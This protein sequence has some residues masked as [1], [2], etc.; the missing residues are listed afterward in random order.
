MIIFLFITNI[1]TFATTIIFIVQNK[2]NKKNLLEK[3]KLVKSLNENLEKLQNEKDILADYKGRF[4]Q[5]TKDSKKIYEENKS[6]KEENIILLNE[7]NELEKKQAILKQKK[8]D[9]LKQKESLEKDKENFLK[10]LSLDLIQQSSEINEKNLKQNQEKIKNITEELLKN[11]ENV[12]NKVFSLDDDNKRREKALDIMRRALL[13]PGG[14]GNS[15]E[16]TLGNILKASGLK[17][18]KNKED[19]GDYILQTSFNTQSS[20][21]IKRPDAIIYLPNNNYIV[22]DSKSSSH[23]INLQEAIDNK[24]K[25][26]EKE[27]LKKIKDRMRK[28]LEDLKS[29]DYEKEYEKYLIKKENDVPPTITMIMFLQTEK[30]LEIIRKA[31][32]NFELMCYKDNIPLATPLGLINLLNLSKYSINKEKQDKNIVKLKW[33]IEKLLNNIITLFSGAKD[34]GKGLKKA[35]NNYDKFAKVFNKN[36]LKRVREI[37]KLGIKSKEKNIP[38]L[39]QYELATTTIE[40]EIEEAKTKED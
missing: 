26:K 32:K 31:D 34:L 39:E 27:I 11:F 33:E 35:L 5:L 40:G 23:F 7:K 38:K 24:D 29:K 22:I 30:M 2:N 18:K 9:L 25:E 28:H 1:I 17:L 15:S 12:K 3:N 14:A 37:E 10:K 16:T 8:E 36:I 13:N 20:E 6:L 4:E 21:S 19:E